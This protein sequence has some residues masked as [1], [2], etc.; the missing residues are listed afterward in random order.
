MIARRA[1]PISP[2]VWLAAPMIAALVLSFVLALPLRIEG[3]ALPEPVFALVPAFAWAIVR[4][5]IL[6]P[7]ALFALGVALDLLWGGPLG[8]WETCLLAAYTLVFVSRRMLSG[9]EFWALWGAYAVAC[10]GAMAV[11]FVLTALR[12]G[13]APGLVGVGL[14]F[15]VTVALYPFAWK[16]VERYEAADTR[17]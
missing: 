5:S 15:A 7:L 2:I 11:G 4:P 1:R 12:A 13:H 9:Q 10:G 8:L 6:P 14:Q 17:Y 16:L 3:L